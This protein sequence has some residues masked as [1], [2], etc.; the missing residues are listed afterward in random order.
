MAIQGYSTVAG[1]N[2]HRAEGKMLKHAE[3]EIVLGM[4]GDF[5]EQ[6]LNKTDTV[7]YRRVKPV[8]AASNETSQID[9]NDFMTSEGTT[10]DSLGLDF[11]DVSVTLVQYAVL[12]KYTSK[13][14]LMYEDDIP[15]EM[16]KLTGQTVASIAEKVAYGQARGGTAVTYANGSTRDAVNTK[17]SLN[18]LRIIA[19]AFDAN[20]AM[21][22]SSAI[23][24]GSE[25]GTR[26]CEPA[27]IVFCHS[28]VEA[29][30]R[31]LSGF[32]KR[33]DYGS[34]TKPLH[35]REFGSV[36]RFRFVQSSM[37]SPFLASGSATLNSMKSLAGAKVDVYPNVVIA[38]SAL[39]HVSLKGHGYTGITP[40]HVSHDTYNHANP[41]G[42]FG[43]VGANFWYNC[44][45]LNENH[46]YRYEVGVSD[47]A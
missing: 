2:L 16:K 37:F 13:S 33:V 38:E 44:V 3:D 17:I 42:M 40:V 24:S 23:K 9:P 46:M 31:D 39:G 47:L 36:E 28:D 29:D 25:Y 19:R 27:F 41:T 4:F 7:I 45:R 20:K 11:T 30:A 21:P 1:R 43:F 12:F 34:A 22:V 32:A 18:K 5:K 15:S 10:P 35:E 14:A 6:P 26:S 8:N